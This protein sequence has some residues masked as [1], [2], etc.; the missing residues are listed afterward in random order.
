[1]SSEPNS[2]YDII[3]P[4][5]FTDMSGEQKHVQLIQKCLPVCQ[6]SANDALKHHIKPIIAA[7][8]GV[9]LIIDIC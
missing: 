7:H 1:L 9:H 2:Q 8:A 6:M 5:G 4:I 3:L